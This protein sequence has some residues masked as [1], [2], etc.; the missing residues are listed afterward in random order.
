M[1]LTLKPRLSP[2]KFHTKLYGTFQRLWHRS[3]GDHHGT[4]EN[5]SLLLAYRDSINRS[6][7][8]KCKGLSVGWIG[9]RLQFR[10]LSS[11]VAQAL[12]SLQVTFHP[13]NQGNLTHGFR[14]LSPF[15]PKIN[16]NSTVSVIPNFLHV[17][18]FLMI[19]LCFFCLWSGSVKCV[20]LTPRIRCTNQVC[21]QFLERAVSDSL[22]P[23]TTIRT[24]Q[25]FCHVPEIAL[26]W[27]LCVLGH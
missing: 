23:V 13:M 15:Q 19:S 7:R 8:G 21:K 25:S 16:T 20:L 4:F 1:F 17:G 2:G 10:A 14:M 18:T 27:S 22:I 11:V 9:G 12:P 26:W 5:T 24:A 6:W 3:K